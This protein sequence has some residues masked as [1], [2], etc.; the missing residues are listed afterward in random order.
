[1]RSWRTEAARLLRFARRDPG[2]TLVTVDRWTLAEELG[3]YGEDALYLRPLEMSDDDVVRVW[4]LAGKIYLKG[5]GRSVGGR[6]SSGG[7]LRSAA[8]TTAPGRSRAAMGRAA[9]SPAP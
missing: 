1:M 3:S 5:E 2:V 9:G 6:V 7:A 4:D 8:R